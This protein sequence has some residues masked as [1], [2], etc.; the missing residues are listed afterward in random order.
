ME[1]IIYCITVYHRKITE[2]HR[3]VN[4]ILINFE[5]PSFFICHNY[6]YNSPFDPSLI[7]YQSIFRERYIIVE[8]II[9]SPILPIS[10]A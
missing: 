1:F 6:S 4:L 7:A 9:N 3:G 10:S 8:R 5:T 2:F